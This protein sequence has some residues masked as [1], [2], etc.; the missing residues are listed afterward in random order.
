MFRRTLEALVV[1]RGGAGAQGAAKR[2]LASALSELASEGVLDRN[3]AE[4]AKEIRVVGNV[5]AHF[6][7]Q[8]SVDQGEAENLSR[9]TRQILHYVYELP[10]SIRRTRAG[11]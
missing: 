2:N 6:D 4:W 3:L 8:Q 9:L 7:P 1:D 10:A 11:N 5:G